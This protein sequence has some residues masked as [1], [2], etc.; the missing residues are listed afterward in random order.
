MGYR[1]LTT[2][3]LEGDISHLSN[4]SIMNTVTMKM[5]KM[6]MRTKMKTRMK[7]ARAN[8]SLTTLVLNGQLLMIVILPPQ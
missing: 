4:K 7:T 5:T 1:R 6:K 8:M 2:V 3:S